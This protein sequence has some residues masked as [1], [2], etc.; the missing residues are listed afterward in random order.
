M[1]SSIKNLARYHPA[2][3]TTGNNDSLVT[4]PGILRGVFVSA[5]GTSPTITVYDSL[6]H[7][8]GTIIATFIP[9]VGFFEM[10][11]FFATGLSITIGGT[12]STNVTALYAAAN[13]T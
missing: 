1:T 13:Q 9:T 5:L 8:S 2:A 11:A 4:G 6:G 10:D 12:G 7:S 3:I